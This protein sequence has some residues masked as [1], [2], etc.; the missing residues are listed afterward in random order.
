MSDRAFLDTNIL[1]Y[2]FDERSPAKKRAAGELAQ[3]LAKEEAVRV[4]ST[5]VLQ[6]AYSALTGKLR[7]DAAWTQTALQAMEASGIR[8]E[9]TDVPLV[10]RAATRSANDRLSFW[11]SLIVESAIS[12]Q[13][14]HLYTED[15]QHGR[16]FGGV[17]VVN[18]FH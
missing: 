3:R 17:T 15:L 10:W 7:L 6:E 9:V 18:P 4:I 1:I 12:A 16:K 2:M 8:V 11:D 5:Q 13:C 14:T